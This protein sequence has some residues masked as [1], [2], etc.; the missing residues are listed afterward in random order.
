MKIKKKTDWLTMITRTIG[1]L[2]LIWS[3]FQLTHDIYSLEETFLGYYFSF[4][5]RIQADSVT[6]VACEMWLLPFIFGF[7]LF[8]IPVE[9]QREF[10]RL[11]LGRPEPLEKID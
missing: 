11:V 10:W 3:F 9:W 5:Q 2:L 1:L 7:A 8:A 4:A 6:G